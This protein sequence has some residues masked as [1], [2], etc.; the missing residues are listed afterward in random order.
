MSSAQT[1]RFV[2]YRLP[3]A[4]QWPELRMLQ[5]APEL[6]LVKEL[7][8]KATIAYFR[9]PRQIEFLA[10]LPRTETGKLQRFKLKK[11]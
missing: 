1:D 7:L 3:S 9:Y 2:H 8:D 11:P 4:E 10:H 6:N 5:G